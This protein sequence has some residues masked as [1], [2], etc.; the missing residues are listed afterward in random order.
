MIMIKATIV[1]MQNQITEIN[2]QIQSSKKMYISEIVGLVV[3]LLDKP[4]TF[5]LSQRS[6]NKTES[7]NKCDIC[8]FQ[9]ENEKLITS[10][11]IDEHDD[12]YYCY[13]WNKYF[14]TKPSFKYHNELIHKEYCN[15]TESEGKDNRQ[16]GS[17]DAKQKDKQ[18]KHRKTKKG[19]NK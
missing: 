6:E 9:S 13:L 8:E 14:E 18:K 5:E 12:C 7:L 15:M 17:N 3:S 10:H 11:M 2:E 4:E 19:V 1:L 16:I